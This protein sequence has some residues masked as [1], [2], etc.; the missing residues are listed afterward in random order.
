MKKYSIALNFLLPLLLWGQLENPIK[1]TASIDHIPRGGEMVRFTVVAAMEEEWH[2]YS[3]HEVADGPLPTEIAVTGDA[4]DQ[5]GRVV[6]PEPIRKFDEGFNTKTSFHA[7]TTEFMVPVLLKQGLPPGEIT[8]NI[9]FFYQVCNASLCY[10]PKEIIL[11]VKTIIEPGQVREEYSDFTAIPAGLSGDELLDSTIQAGIIPFI[12]LSLTMGFLALL[13]PCVFPMIPITVSFFTHQGEKSKSSPVRQASIYAL[14]IIMTFSVLGI[15]LAIF[16]GASGANQLAANPWVNL[17]LGSLFVYFALSLFG[18]YEIQLPEGLRQFTLKRESKAGY[19]GILFMAFTFTLTSFTCTVQFVGLLLVAAAKGMWFWPALGMVVFSAAFALPFFFLAL[20]PQYLARM[21][22]SGGWLNAVKVVMGFL[23][24]AAAFKFYSN[25]DLV[26]SW[27]IFTNTSV[28]ALWTVIMFFTGI[29]L[30]GKLRLPHDSPVETVSVPRMLLSLFFLTFSLYLGSGLMGRP[31]H[32]LIYSYLPPKIAKSGE[33][34]SVNDSVAEDL[35]W[36]TSLDEGFAIARATGKPIFVDFTG[37]TCTNCRW[38]E[39]NMFTD[40]RVKNLFQHYVLVQLYTDGGEGYQE[41][42]KYEIDRF[43]TA[44][45]PYYVLLSPEDE[46]L[47]EFPGMTRD[48][49]QFITFLK[50]GLEG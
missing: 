38:M 18:M 28:L 50:K 31:I 25:T 39:S 12:L 22:K 42:Q 44:A 4:I 7:G 13:T 1:I 27:N 6:E 21:P 24:L 37:Y 16:L 20:F 32:G 34:V 29:Y 30:L 48:F 43:G 26:W 36:M 41:N 10:P 11:P 35:Q 9:R 46:V 45:L 2:I 5:V 23:E 19:A 15:I 8:F 14:G 3:V 17:F 49:N 47:G 40:Q 33:V